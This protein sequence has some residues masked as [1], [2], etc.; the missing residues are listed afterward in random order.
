MPLVCPESEGHLLPTTYF[1]S[2]IEKLVLAHRYLYYVLNEPT[3]SDQQFD[4]MEK[5][6]VKKSN[7]ESP[8]NRPGS[9]LARSYSAE[10]IEIALEL[11]S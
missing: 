9:D 3:I 7:P 4:R 1:M 2:P 5:E 11:K 6:A 10:I 8:V